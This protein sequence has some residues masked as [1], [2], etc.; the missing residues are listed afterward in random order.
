LI[1]LFAAGCGSSRE[2]EVTGEIKAAATAKVT[3]PLQVKFIEVAKSS[4][5]QDQVRKTITAP[6]GK[7]SEKVE[8]E[9]SSI[10]VFALDDTNKDGACTDGEAWGQADAEV[11]SDDTVAPVALEISNAACPKAA[12]TSK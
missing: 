3:G 8:V 11:K 10:R 1:A 6:L 5:E 7:F 4:G 2:V 9:G 12:A